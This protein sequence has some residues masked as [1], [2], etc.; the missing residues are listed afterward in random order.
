MGHCAAFSATGP[1]GLGAYEGDTKGTTNL[2][3]GF[4]CGVKKASAQ[5]IRSQLFTVDADEPDLLLAE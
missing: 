5:L 1:N 2:E 4:S 3:P